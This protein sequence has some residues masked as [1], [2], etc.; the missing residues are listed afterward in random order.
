MQVDFSRRGIPSLTPRDRVSIRW[1]S[2]LT[3]VIFLLVPS[4]SDLCLSGPNFIP[5]SMGSLGS[6]LFFPYK[7]V[8]KARIIFMLEFID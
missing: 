7:Y 3:F 6:G 4:F 1:E 2:V 8:G 5:N